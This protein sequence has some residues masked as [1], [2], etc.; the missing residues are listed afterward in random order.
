MIA[1]ELAGQARQVEHAQGHAGAFENFLV[2][3]AVLLQRALAAAHV[4]QR[5]YRQQGTEQRQQALADQCR[6]QLLLG[7]ACV[8]Q[9]TQLPGAVVDEGEHHALQRLAA[10]LH[11]SVAF[12]Y[13][14]AAAV[15]QQPERVARAVQMHGERLV[16]VR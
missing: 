7:Q 6:Q 10:G 11:R 14:A 4:E 16:I 2:A 5:Q 15:F 1:V 9:A 3:P 12:Q 8:E 13:L